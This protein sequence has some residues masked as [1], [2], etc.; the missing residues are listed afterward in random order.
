MRTDKPRRLFFALWPDEDCRQALLIRQHGLAL[1]GKNARYVAAGNLHLTLHFIGHVFDPELC[2]LQQQAHLTGAKRFEITLDTPGYFKKSQVAWIGCREKPQAL[3][4]LHEAL[5]ERL[6]HCGFQ[7][8]KR[9]Y[10]P[11]V[12]LIRKQRLQPLSNGF[13]PLRWP[14]SDFVLAESVPVEGGVRY[15]LLERYA[16]K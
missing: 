8:E 11:H 10:N 7:L 16:L 4:A 15:D 13:E 6:R 3:L 9:R 2:C 5:G 1:Q 14:V 12:T